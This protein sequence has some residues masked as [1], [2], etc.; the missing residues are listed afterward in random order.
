MLVL[1]HRDVES[2]AGLS[3]QETRQTRCQRVNRTQ[4]A[5]PISRRVMFFAKA[6]L[7]VADE[8]AL[9]SMLPSKS[10]LES[11]KGSQDKEEFRKA[12]TKLGSESCLQWA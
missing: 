4:P 7:L 11:A 9:E 2:D 1:F 6:T 10:A 5:N 3:G 8:S 12:G